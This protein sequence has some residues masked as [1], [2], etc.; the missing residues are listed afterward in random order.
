MLNRNFADATA[1]IAAM[2]KPK[3]EAMQTPDLGMQFAQAMRAYQDKKEY[4]EQEANKTSLVEAIKGGNPEEIRAAA[5]KYDADLGLQYF[6]N[7]QAKA[8]DFERQ[9][10]LLGIENQYNVAAAE[11]RAAL[12][13]EIA[14]IKAGGNGLVNINM[15]NPFDKKRIETIAKNMDEN[16]STAQGVYDTYKQALDLLNAEDVKTGGA[17]NAARGASGKLAGSALLNS[18]EQRLNALINETIPK[19]RPV[20]SGSASDKD[21]ETFAKATLGFGNTKDA[22]KNIASGRM[23]AAENSMAMEELRAE[24]VTSGMG[25]VSDFDREWRRYLNANPI[26][27]DKGGLN[28]SRVDAYSWF[29]GNQQSVDPKV[30]QALDAG[31]SMD[32]INAF[33]GR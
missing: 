30:Q 31:W 18:N 32:E 12:E 27:N 9:K 33:L 16:I 11:K 25:S 7:D 21:M 29:G 22:N 4:D 28:K 8:Q 23:L 2:H 3:F 15:N 5:A 13:R 6:M 20:G 10:E 17:W 26:F 24:Y 14:R 19:M 1:R